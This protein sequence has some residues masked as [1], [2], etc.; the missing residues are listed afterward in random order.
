ML[1]QWLN[2]WLAGDTS[3]KLVIEEEVKDLSGLNLKD[4][5]ESHY[6]WKD[7]LDAQLSG[8]D[9]APIDVAHLASDCQCQ[10]GKWLHSVGKQK[11]DKLPEY[12]SAIDAHAKF[13]IAAAEVVIEYHSGA[14]DR[15][16]ELLN[17][18]FRSASNAVQLELV[19]LFTSARK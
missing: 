13:H 8:E 6:A 7:R 10:L 18:N 12:H 5:L 11:Y 14:T 17:T 4:S 15:A 3:Q 9:D 1:R 2:N 16:K 19:K